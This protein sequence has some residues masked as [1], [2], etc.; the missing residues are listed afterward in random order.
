MAI[1]VDSMEIESS[2]Y[3]HGITAEDIRH[4]VRNAV[5]MHYM[6]GYT[7]LIGPGQS[8]QLLELC[9]SGDERI[10]HAMKAR[11]KFLRMKGDLS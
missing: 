8:G 3:R 4:A 9:V 6:D 10:F 11:K 5:K 2:A 1:I 7:L